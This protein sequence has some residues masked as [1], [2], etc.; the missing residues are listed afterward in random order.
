MKLDL[1]F[2]ANPNYSR[3][4]FASNDGS[5]KKYFEAKLALLL[6]FRFTS[7]SKRE[8]F[9][10]LICFSLFLRNRMVHKTI[11]LKEL[12]G[13]KHWD[14]GFTGNWGSQRWNPNIFPRFFWLSDSVSYTKFQWFEFPKVV[15]SVLSLSL[16]YP[17]SSMYC[18]KTIHLIFNLN[19]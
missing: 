7:R 5:A 3:K 16:Q 10:Y 19:Y 8:L 15:R 12:L 4:L 13:K 2:P 17:T 18:W 11:C 9:I 14:F 1:R 6:P